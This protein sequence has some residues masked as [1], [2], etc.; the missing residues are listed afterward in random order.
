MVLPL[1]GDL[2]QIRIRISRASCYLREPPIEALCA[3]RAIEPAQRLLAS[4]EPLNVLVSL[5]VC[6]GQI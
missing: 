3:S 2:C 1:I 4:L 6:N 5:S